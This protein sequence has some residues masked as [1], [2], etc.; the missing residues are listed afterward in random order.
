MAKLFIISNAKPTFTSPGKHWIRPSTGQIYGYINGDWIPIAGGEPYDLAYRYPL[1]IFINGIDRTEDVELRSFTATKILNSQVDSCGFTLYDDYNEIKPQVG[2]QILIYWKESPDADPVSYFGGEISTAPISEQAPGQRN[3]VYQISCVDYGRQLKRKLA[4]ESYTDQYAGD[5]IKNLIATYC[6]EYT[7]ENVQTGKLVSFIS[8][9][10]KAIDQCIKDLA[11]ATGYDWYVD[12]DRD[13]H[14]FNTD[15]A[16]T[17]FILTEDILTTGHYRNLKIQVDKTQLR[18]KVTVRGG[19][20][21]SD[22]YAQERVADGTQA[23]FALDYKP[24]DPVSVYID[25]GAGYVLKTLGID[26]IDKAGSGKD[27]VLNYTDKVI[28]NLDLANLAAGTKIKCTYKYEVQVL[29][30]D[31]DDISIESI[32]EIEGGDGIYEYL[33]S[34]SS[35]E[36]L[37]MAHD[38]AAAELDESANPHISGT[39]VTDQ[40]GYR[41]GQ[42]LLLMLPT[43]GHNNKYF[44]VQKVVAKVRGDSKFEYTVT[45]ATNLK[46]LTDLIVKLIDKGKEVIV[47]QNETLHDMSRV[48]DE[49][50]LTE[51]APLYEEQTP[52]YQYG[53]GGSPQG[54]WNE[55]QWG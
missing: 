42:L 30:E 44:L 14:F 21:L 2:E 54:V 51:A 6:P 5:I 16:L 10:Y 9:N 43:W 52:P 11:D 47:R 49:M 50:A 36:T 46:G 55:S 27:F 19:V 29:T 12:E 32:K 18:N 26:N 40:D 35:I 28:K 4:V 7:V 17:P 8:F 37:E 34:D 53:P 15:T 45:F 38:K 24:R 22:L 3:F 31:T 48:S 13:L 41:P 25:T 33:I 23:S 20:F 39:F 1:T